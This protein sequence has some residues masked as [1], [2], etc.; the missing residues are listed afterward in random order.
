[1]AVDLAGDTGEMREI[2]KTEK[3]RKVSLL[4]LFYIYIFVGCAA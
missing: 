2:E 4:T 3:E 1:M